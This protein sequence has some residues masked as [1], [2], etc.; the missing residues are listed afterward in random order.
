MTLWPSYLYFYLVL[1]LLEFYHLLLLFPVGATF[2]FYL[3]ISF[4]CCF[5]FTYFLFDDF[6]GDNYYIVAHLEWL[7]LL[8][9]T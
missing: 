1:Y 3:L 7:S 2:Y 9:V 5:L 4:Y 8:W 6:I